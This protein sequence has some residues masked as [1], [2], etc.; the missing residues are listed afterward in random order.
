MFCI[1]IGQI[2]KSVYGQYGHRYRAY[3]GG[4][5]GIVQ[6]SSSK[7]KAETKHLCQ[8]SSVCCYKATFIRL[9]HH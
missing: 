6:S 9:Y 4:D 8:F 1:N 5:K 7:L 3:G 2:S